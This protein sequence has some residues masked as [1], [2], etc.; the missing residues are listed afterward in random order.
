[1]AHMAIGFYAAHCWPQNNIGN[2]SSGPA[3]PVST[4][5]LVN[6]ASNWAGPGRRVSQYLVDTKPH[7]QS[8]AIVLA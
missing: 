1:M 6:Y 8:N 2:K 7:K 4:K 5:S 3:N